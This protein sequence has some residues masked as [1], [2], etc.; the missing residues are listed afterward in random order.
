MNETSLTIADKNLARPRM[1]INSELIFFKNDI[2]SDIKQVEAKITKKISKENDETQKKLNQVEN[3]LESL[4]QK[5][6]ALSNSASENS[7]M[8]DKVDSLYSFRTKIEN[9]IFSHDFKINSITKDL[10]DAIN[11]FDRLI[12]NNILYQ[13]IIGTNNARFQTFHNFIDYVLTN[14]SQLNIFKDKTMSLDFKQYK[15]KLDTM[16]DGLKKQCDDIM[17]NNRNFTI[18]SIENF[19]KKLKSDFELYNQKLFNLKIKN[20]EQCIE[21]EKITNNLIK[22]W[23]K[24]YE[25]KKQIDTTCDHTL[26]SLKKHYIVTENRLNECMKDYND[27]KKKFEL[28]LEFMK[29]VKSFGLSGFG[30]RMTFQ[31]FV[32]LKENPN[33]FKKKKQ[34]VSYLKKY[35]VGEVGMDQIS[36]LAKKH[37]RKNV[38]L[39]ENYSGSLNHPS[40]SL[41]LRK[42]TT[43]N[44]NSHNINYDNNNNNNLTIN[45]SF[46]DFINNTN[47]N[48]N[49]NP[50]INY[51]ASNS[52]INII[53]NI[54]EKK[55][56]N[57]DG[58][59]INKSFQRFKS[60]NF[61]TKVN[62][63]NEGNNDNI[64]ESHDKMFKNN[65][66]NINKTFSLRSEISDVII[67]NQIKNNENKNKD[68]I[69]DRNNKI[70]EEEENNNNTNFNILNKESPN[71]NNN[72]NDMNK[73]HNQNQ[74]NN[75]R[76]IVKFSDINNE[77]KNDKKNTNEQK[78][79]KDIIIHNEKN[80]N[81]KN[82]FKTLVKN[83]INNIN[84]IGEK[85]DYQ[86]KYIFEPST[87]INYSIKYNQ[88]NTNNINNPN[89]VNQINNNNI[90]YNIDNNSQR[91]NKNINLNKD[92]NYNINNI[93][94]EKNENDD[95]IDENNSDKNIQDLVYQD[96]ENNTTVKNSENNIIKNNN[97]EIQNNYHHLYYP[98]N[99]TFE[100]PESKKNI[101]FAFDKIISDKENEPIKDDK[102]HV[103]VN[104]ASKNTVHQL[105]RGDVKVLSSFKIIKDGKEIKVPKIA[106][107]VKNPKKNVKKININNIKTPI[108]SH[109]SLNFFSNH[110]PINKTNYE[111]F[112]D[113]ITRN[114]SIDDNLDYNDDI[115][116]YSNDS[117]ENNTN[118]NRDRN[119]NNNNNKVN[120]MNNTDNR[121]MSNKNKYPY[122]HKEILHIVH[123]PDIYEKK[124]NEN[125]NDRK[126]E[127]YNE[128]LN[129][130]KILRKISYDN[131]LY[132]K[133][134][135]PK[136]NSH[137]ENMRNNAR[138]MN[139]IFDNNKNMRSYS[140][141]LYNNNL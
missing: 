52:S 122:K 91:T 35:I 110:I 73:N 11:K 2:L 98:S 24:I 29:G 133:K 119:Y 70:I 93:I 25:I 12:E 20:S 39:H 117:I 6:F 15:N 31:D 53:N 138:N 41:F 136:L 62:S 84:Y 77:N 107:T 49:E 85:K 55:S 95:K 48:S 106:N 8:K 3:K 139:V 72:K 26:N 46:A 135:G 66:I 140:G 5:L 83:H 40:T 67:E 90:N 108:K 57:K 61:N 18:Q 58:T 63:T 45:N 78:L 17:I 102:G 103:L 92:Y 97:N 7:Q 123:L 104:N 127:D 124:S 54:D 105:L 81:E 30:S 21:L 113:V 116:Y 112:E 23:E 118:R 50:N 51:Q 37:S 33:D 100:Y 16:V 28:L 22:E 74:I 87:E 114:K 130:I 96:K 132:R 69:L 99:N 109:S 120:K 126:I 65:I 47:K 71:N 4:T 80:T 44:F 79:N 56:I 115:N 32:N 131:D 38:M 9:T 10:T 89:L 129:H 42:S 68:L 128:D 59:K 88:N 64:E 121:S 75:F 34:A 36:E 111:Y 101:Q 86:E 27:I 1:S 13:G 125:D 137:N 76:G 60:S 14:I 134:F 19:E 43:N 82:G 94:I 141:L